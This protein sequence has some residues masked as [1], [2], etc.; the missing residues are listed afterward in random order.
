MIDVKTASNN[1]D[2]VSLWGPYPNYDDIARLEYGRLLWR[3]PEMRQRLL[4]HWLDP[5]HPYKDRFGD[6]R[7]LIEEVLTSDASLE[8]LDFRLGQRG[9]SLRTIA[10]EIPPVFGSF[11]NS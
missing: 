6:H 3:L 9:A 2:G 11:W 4:S 8:V 5:R 1:Q 7:S 10:R